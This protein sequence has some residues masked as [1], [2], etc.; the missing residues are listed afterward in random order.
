MEAIFSLEWLFQPLHLLLVFVILAALVFDFVNGF[1]DAANAIATIVVSKTLTPMQAVIMAGFANFVGYFWIGTAV[2]KMV[3]KGVIDFPKT[4]DSE[5]ALIILLGALL[6]AIGWNLITWILGLP[7]S[8]SH[9]LVGGLTGAAM[10]SWFFGSQVGIV[11]AGLFKI[12]AF[13]IVAP[14]VGMIGAI[15]FTIVI[16][17]VFRKTTPRKAGWLFRRLQL[18][19]SAFYSIGHGTNDA[20]KSMGVITMA[21]IVA[22][23]QTGE[24]AKAFEIPH[25]VVLSCYAAIAIGTMSG[26]WRIVKTMGTSITKIRQQEGFCSETAAAAVLMTTAHFGIPVSTTHVISGSIMGVGVV[27]GARKVRWTTARRILWAWVIT[28]PAA[29]SVAAISTILLGKLVQ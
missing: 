10:G 23:M 4:M 9:A 27:E 11:W 5:M 24:A 7:T 12:F 22:G 25:W 28:I 16:M 19:S 8:S 21:L 17:W 15:L 18:V 2:A 13:I 14:S 20:Q 26:G 6:G 29:G 3:G 1:H